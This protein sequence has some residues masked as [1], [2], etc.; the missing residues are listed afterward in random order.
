MLTGRER[1]VSDNWP[2]TPTFH[3]RADRCPQSAPVADRVPFIAGEKD[4]E[5]LPH[6]SY[7]PRHSLAIQVFQQRNGILAG[8]FG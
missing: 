3:C 7:A 5:D 6:V 1:S 4:L 8:Y 2:H